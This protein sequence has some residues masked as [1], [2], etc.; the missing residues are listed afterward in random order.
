LEEQ[1]KSYEEII[2]I[3]HTYPNKTDMYL[4]PS[5]LNQLKRSGRVSTPQAIFA[6][7]L[8]INVLLRF[9][10]GKVVIEDKIRTKKRAKRRFFQVIEDAV[11]K[12]QLKEM[13]IMHAG[14]KE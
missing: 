13:C 4:L 3:L 12:H 14:V 5:S 2:D 9:D 7:L 1:G 11:N 6:S 10:N 8:N